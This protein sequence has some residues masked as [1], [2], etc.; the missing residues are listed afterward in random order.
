MGESGQLPTYLYR[1]ACSEQ[2]AR[3]QADEAL[4]PGTRL[5]VLPYGEGVYE[6]FE[7]S[8]LGANRHYIRFDD[9]DRT[10]K[11]ALKVVCL[12]CLLLPLPPLRLLPHM[13]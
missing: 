9:S 5:R 7:W 12:L 2:R 4:L 1:K 11:I 13:S 10:E 3:G 6:R 8:A